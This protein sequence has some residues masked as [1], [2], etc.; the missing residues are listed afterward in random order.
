MQDL[1]FS[2]RRLYLLGYNA[3]QSIEVQPTFCRIISPPSSV[4][5]SIP[6][7]E[8]LLAA[9]FMLISYIEVEGV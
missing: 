1:R 3:V 6:R 8:A 4:L 7:K 2:Q 5:K 9:C